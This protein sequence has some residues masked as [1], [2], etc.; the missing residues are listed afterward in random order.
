MSDEAQA[1]PALRRGTSHPGTGLLFAYDTTRFDFAAWARDTLAATNLAL[2]HREH[3]T[4]NAARESAVRALRDAYPAIRDTFRAFVETT[5]QSVLGPLSWYQDPPIFRVH[6]PGTDSVSPL[7]KDR[8][9]TPSRA[10]LSSLRRRYHNVWVPLT[11][12]RDGCALWLES[13]EGSGDYAPVSLDYGQ[14][15]IFDGMNL[16]HGS[17]RNDTGR[18]RVSLE[19]RCI[20]I[21]Q[22]PGEGNGELGTAG[23]VRSS[24]DL[25]CSNGSRGFSNTQSG[26][27]GEPGTRGT[28]R[29]V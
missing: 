15:F 13:S 11:D 29:G 1:P 18:T 17:V 27:L 21:R 14:A 16:T 26:R 28:P 19:F 12:V 2:A 9:F 23:D 4:T 20:S 24:E 3:G 8:D 10:T 6:F 5:A 25:P 22:N 7:H